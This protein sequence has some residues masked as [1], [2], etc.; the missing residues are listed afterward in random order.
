M[1]RWRWRG[2]VRDNLHFREEARPG[3]M[4]REVNDESFVTR[5]RKNTESS[6]AAATHVAPTLAW[7][8]HG[9][10]NLHL[11]PNLQVCNRKAT[12]LPLSQ[13]WYVILECMVGMDVN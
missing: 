11:V 10:A 3:L 1:E 2:V 5:R 4:V 9:I 6:D 12:Y 7:S 8:G 13:Y